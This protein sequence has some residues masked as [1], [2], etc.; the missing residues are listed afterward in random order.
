MPRRYAV[1]LSALLLFSALFGQDQKPENGAYDMPNM[2]MP[3]HNM[4]D[5]PGM[6]AEGGVHAMH[7][8]ENRHLDMGPHMKMTGLRNPRPGDS[9]RRASRRSR[10]QSGREIHGLQN[11]VGGW[12]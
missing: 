6:D 7:S 9:Q 5:M 12:F 11:R 8:M 4:S 10:P 2:D 3:G 1:L